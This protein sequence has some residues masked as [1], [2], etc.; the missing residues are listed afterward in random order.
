MLTSLS[1]SDKVSPLAVTTPFE[2]TLAERTAAVVCGR[3]ARTRLAQEVGLGGAG[4]SITL[5]SADSSAPTVE[6]R[7]LTSRVVAGSSDVFECEDTTESRWAL[8]V[9]E[10]LAGRTGTTGTTG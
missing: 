3:V 1:T 6:D 4:A 8:R 2:E 10:G 7:R 5:T 9:A